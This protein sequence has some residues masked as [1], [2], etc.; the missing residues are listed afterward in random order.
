MFPAIKN[1][2]C[3]MRDEILELSTEN[4]ISKTKKGENENRF[5]ETKEKLLKSFIDEK[6]S[7]FSYRNIEKNFSNFKNDK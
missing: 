5:K 3:F 2:F 1:G 4:D 6:K 7:Q